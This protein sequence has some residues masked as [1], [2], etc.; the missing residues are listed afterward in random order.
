MKKDEGTGE[1]LNGIYSWCS[2]MLIVKDL[3][4][5]T[6][7]V[8]IQNLLKQEEFEDVFLLCLPRE[9]QQDD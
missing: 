6:I 9:E 2:D 3:R 4:L 5:E 1:G 8:S 7:E